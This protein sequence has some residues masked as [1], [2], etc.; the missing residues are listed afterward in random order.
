MNKAKNT[1]VTGLILGIILLTAT[2]IV[3]NP[4]NLNIHAWHTLGVALL[5]ACWWLTE[6]IPLPATGLVPIV[7][8]PILGIISL[9][10]CITI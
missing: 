1:K 7:L 4:E 9:F 2:Y 6:A 8:F 3:P 10:S 5:M